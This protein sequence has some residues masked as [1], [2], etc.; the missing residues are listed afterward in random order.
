MS[1]RLSRERLLLAGLLVAAGGGYMAD[2]YLFAGEA[3]S[4]ADEFAVPSAASAAKPAKAAPAPPEQVL[5]ARLRDL[6]GPTAQTAAPLR[7]IFGATPL[8]KVIQPVEPVAPVIGEHWATRKLNG[9][10]FGADG[11]GI[12]IVDGRLLKLG[13]RLDGMRLTRV[14]QHTA[15]FSDATSEITLQISQKSSPAD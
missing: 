11:K 12:A 5:A 13:A 4:A 15:T 14:T 9:V 2:Q 10:M 3:A 6:A 7:D 8:P 1:I